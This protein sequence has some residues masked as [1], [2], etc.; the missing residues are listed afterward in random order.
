MRHGDIYLA[1][2]SLKQRLMYLRA[3]STGVAVPR[4]DFDATIHSVF[5]SALNLRLTRG[6]KLLTLVASSEA[7]LPQGI[8]VDTPDN[9][10]FEIFHAGE[11]ANCWD[12]IYAS[13]S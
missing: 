4:M 5:R 7:D 10:S 3:I 9:F 2:L 11:Q 6:S 13:A 8:R 1:A 12:G